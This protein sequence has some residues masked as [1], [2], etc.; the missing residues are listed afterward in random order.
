MISHISPR[1]ILR[2]YAI[3]IFATVVFVVV[4]VGL[5]LGHQYALASVKNLAD[6]NPLIV[7]DQ[8]SLVSND[9]SPDPVIEQFSDSA[10]PPSESSTS[11]GSTAGTANSQS[12]SGSSSSQRSVASGGSS[13]GGSG[14][15]KPPTQ[16]AAFA[17]SLGSIED[18]TTR[19]STTVTLL[20]IVLGCTVDHQ[21]KITVSGQNG[22]GTL[23]Y[24]WVRSTGGEATN[25]QKEFPAGSSSV[26]L[27]H[28]M[29]T[30]SWGDY[31]VTLEVTAPSV[32]EKK[33]TFSHRC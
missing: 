30:S 23:K 11:G 18:H 20:G 10:A 24:R 27:T 17:A 4:F 12:Q 26:E 31:S 25:E 21:F 7:S 1:K 8:S 32:M 9:Q 28:S 29:T 33:Y 14:T 15:T 2:D 22:P 5:W 16:Q 3:P 19:T 13:G 6:T